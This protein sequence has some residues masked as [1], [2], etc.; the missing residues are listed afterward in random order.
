[1]KSILNQSKQNLMLHVANSIIK[2]AKNDFTV[3][4][5]D[6]P[7]INKIPASKRIQTK[8]KENALSEYNVITRCVTEQR[9]SSVTETSINE[10]KEQKRIPSYCMK[11]LNYKYQKK[12]F[13]QLEQQF[14]K[15]LQIQPEKDVVH[16]I[17]RDLSRTIKAENHF[18]EIRNILTAFSVYDPNIGYVQGMNY[19]ASILF[20]H[21]KQEWI[22][23]WL[24]VSLIEQMEIRDIFQLSLNAINK[25][26]KILDF[27]ISRFLP[28]AYENLCLKQV[29]TELYIQQWILSLL[30]QFIPFEYTQMYLDGLFKQGISYFYMIALTI[31]KVFDKAIQ[32]EDQ[33]EILILLTSKQYSQLKWP[34]I[35]ALQWDIN[36]G[37]LR[38]L[39][40]CF[41]SD[42]NTFNKPKFQTHFSQL[43]TNFFQFIKSS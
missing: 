4:D 26:S 27:L 43:T 1:M 20:N 21:A 24:F 34:S 8:P 14:L 33:I 41:D 18:K 13:V 32:E 42:T 12:E 15:I 2:N 25:Y 29:N 38:V 7:T 5:C 23:F 28:K 37:E 19:I 6:V 3:K 17:E 10:Q 35:L 31:I 30:L 22:A 9:K 16:Q 39:L 40:D 36:P 11:W